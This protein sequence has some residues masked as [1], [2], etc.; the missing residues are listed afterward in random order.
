MAWTTPKTWAS[1]PLTSTDLN[2]YIRDNQ[3]FL[4]T[5]MENNAEHTADESSDYTTTTQSFVDVDATNFALTITTNGGNVLVGFN[6]LTSTHRTTS[7]GPSFNVAVDSVDYFADDGITMGGTFGSSSHQS[8]VT[9]VVL[10]TGLSAGV[11]V[12]KLRWRS[13]NNGGSTTCTLFAGSGTTN[14]DVHPQFW[15]QEL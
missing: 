7:E 14:A 12:F 2:T 9:F 6:G 4:M 8:P 11:H 15:V 3:D 1:E 13:F 10:I 5:R